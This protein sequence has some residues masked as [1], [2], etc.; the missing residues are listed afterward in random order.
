VLAVAVVLIGAWL[1][2]A[3]TTE[4]KFTNVPESEQGFAV[5]EERFRD[6][7]KANEVVI[8]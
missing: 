2:D 6:L 3:L 4:F 7:R 1:D 8:V 5:M